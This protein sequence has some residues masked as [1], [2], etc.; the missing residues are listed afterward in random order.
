M[1]PNEQVK[2]CNN[3]RV[4]TFLWLLHFNTSVSKKKSLT[5][6]NTCLRLWYAEMLMCRNAYKVQIY[7]VTRYV[8]YFCLCLQIGN[9]YSLG[10]DMQK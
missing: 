9:L 6:Y 8:L 3:C 4:K 7:I 10:A 2:Y 5:K 1:T